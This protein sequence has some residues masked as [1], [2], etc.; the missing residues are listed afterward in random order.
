MT[1][2]T[3]AGLDSTKTL[4]PKQFTL[5]RQG[6]EWVLKDH[7]E[8]VSNRIRLKTADSLLIAKDTIIA[9]QDRQ[10]VRLE[11]QLKKRG[12]EVQPVARSDT[13][14]QKRQLVYRTIEAWGWRALAVYVLVRNIK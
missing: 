4:V 5:N 10:I 6:A 2:F 9:K 3:T 7:F 8:L 12:S 13:G 11:T 1:G 14:R